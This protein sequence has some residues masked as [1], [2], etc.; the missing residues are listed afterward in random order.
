MASTTQVRCSK[1]KSEQVYLSFPVS[2]P[3]TLDDISVRTPFAGQSQQTALS[4]TTIPTAQPAAKSSLS[5]PSPIEIELGCNQNPTPPHSTPD[6][7]SEALGRN[8]SVEISRNSMLSLTHCYSPPVASNI[9]RSHSSI[10]ELLHRPAKIPYF[11]L[12]NKFDSMNLGAYIM[13]P[14]RI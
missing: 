1:I 12:P 14:S 10:T 13:F 6:L 7:S 5:C 9:Q 8:I 11:E 2:S 3:T 4:L